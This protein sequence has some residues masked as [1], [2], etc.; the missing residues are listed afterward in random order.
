MAD[1]KGA[2][3]RVDTDEN[4]GRAGMRAKNLAQVALEAKK[5]LW[6]E[7]V[8]V[9]VDELDGDAVGEGDGVDELDADEVQA[10]KLEAESSGQFQTR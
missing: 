4:E 10:W 7:N 1:P 5:Q 8:T 9:A 3:A 6:H 2:L